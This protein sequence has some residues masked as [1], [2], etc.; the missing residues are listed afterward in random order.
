MKALLLLLAC[1][2][3]LCVVLLLTSS[4]SLDKMKTLSLLFVAIA[5]KNYDEEE[6]QTI[7]QYLSSS[8][9]FSMKTMT[10]K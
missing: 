7:V 3:E 5:T 4:K 1:N 8:E 10:C 9:I 6:K 2:K